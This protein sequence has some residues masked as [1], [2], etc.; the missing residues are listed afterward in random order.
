METRFDLYEL[1]EGHEARF[2]E[3]LDAATAHRQRNRTVLGW[4][5]TAAAAFVCLL[6]V[7]PIGGRHFRGAHTPEA[8]YVAYLDKVGS[9]YELLAEN[10]SGETGEWE[11]ALTALT[12]ETIP[13]FDQLPDEMSVRQKTRILKQYY[14]QLLD[15]AEQL[16]HEWNN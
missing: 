5:L 3:K 14:G 8:V 12:G 1:P 2:L 10:T 15:G 13:L 9:Y 7:L 11:A 4:T 16:K 6:L